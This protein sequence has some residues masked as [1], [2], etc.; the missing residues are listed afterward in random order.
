MQPQVGKAV[1]ETSSLR[2][3]QSGLRREGRGNLARNACAQPQHRGEVRSLDRP[4]TQSSRGRGYRRGGRISVLA[5]RNLARN[6]CA[7]PQ[8]R[9][10]LRSLDRPQMQT[11]RGPLAIGTRSAC[12]V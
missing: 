3:R 5:N 8:H 4:Q 12:T 7:Q 6:A 11:S 1:A 9:G 10:D 2:G